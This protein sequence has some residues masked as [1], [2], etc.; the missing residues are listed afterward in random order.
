VHRWTHEQLAAC[1]DDARRRGAEIL[2]ESDELTRP[3]ALLATAIPPMATLNVA[4]H[5]LHMLPQGAREGL[6]VELLMTAEKNAAD[7]LHRCHRALELDGDAHGYTAE[8]WLAMV[9]DIALPLL[10]SARGD[11]EPPTIVGLTQEAVSWLSRSVLEL[12]QS[13]PETPTALAEALARLLTVW[14]F[15]ELAR[16][17]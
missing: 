5:V 4:V 17:R 10:E 6:D 16:Q 3:L 12:D 14:L 15:A 13:S 2:G 9:Y 8:D 1:Y 7:A 11:H